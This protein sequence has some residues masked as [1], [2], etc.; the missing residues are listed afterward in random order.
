MK[1][2]ENFRH[3]LVLFSIGFIA[4]IIGAY[5]LDPIV[6]AFIL[7]FLAVFAL[8]LIARL[9]VCVATKRKYPKIMTLSLLFILPLI[10]GVLRLSFWNNN[11]L[12][13]LYNLKDN[14]ALYTCRITSVPEES[15]YSTMLATA[16][17]FKITNDSKTMDVS[18]DI[19]LA[20]KN[21]SYDNI[22][23][24]DTVKFYAAWVP[25]ND[26]FSLYRKSKNQAASFYVGK[27]IKVTGENAPKN[28]FSDLGV[29]L[30]D[31]ILKA[32]DK[33]YSYNPESAAVVKA[34]LTGD[35]SDFSDSLYDAF[36]DAGFLHV[37]AISGTHV[38]ILFSF[39]SVLLLNLRINR[40]AVVLICTVI[41]MIFSSVAAFTPSVLRASIM[42]ILS[43]LSVILNKEYDSLTALF[44]SALVILL[45]Y[46]YALFTPGF[47]LSFGAT[48]GIVLFYTRFSNGLRKLFGKPFK[49][50]TESLALSAAAFLGTAPFTLAAFGSLSL[51]SLV[52]NIWI[53]PLVYVIFCLGF[54]TC[55]LFYIFP[56]AAFVLRFLSEPCIYVMLKT[57]KVFSG[58]RFGIITP[59]FVPWC[60][61]AYYASFIFILIYMLRNSQKSNRN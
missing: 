19:Q 20:Y 13:V 22:G 38:S 50:L 34:V 16:R 6:S 41:I 4:G 26:S 18:F 3:Y 14:N 1:A 32:A 21:T 44:F 10:A 39:L 23:F 24:G 15:A 56:P 60:F 31:K 37:A 54:L 52:T 42:L 28:L 45:I 29:I 17:V 36:A 55:I 30:R 2:I 48:L 25:E 61:Y 51:W 8:V 5:L 27:C 9:T 53:V 58:L 47:L 46:P 33:V 59:D 40:K 57:A 49:S 7:I 11:A 12:K 35:K 43:T